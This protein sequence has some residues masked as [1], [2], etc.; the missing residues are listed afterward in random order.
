MRGCSRSS[1]RGCSRSGV[2]GRGPLRP[3]PLPPPR[4][5]LPLPRRAGGPAA[6]CGS[7]RSRPA[8]CCGRGRSPCCACCGRACGRC[9]AAGRGRH[10]GGAAG[11]AAPRHLAAGAPLAAPCLR[12][13]PALAPRPLRPVLAALAAAAPPPS[14][15]RGAAAAASPCGPWPS[16]AAPASGGGPLRPPPPAP[17]PPARA[18]WRCAAARRCPTSA[19]Y[20]WA[21][22]LS[23]LA[24]AAPPA[25]ARALTAHRPSDGG[26]LRGTPRCAARPPIIVQGV[27]ADTPTP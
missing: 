17:V 8:P 16:R 20:H 27:G 14:L 19:R 24:R 5:S 4:P 9:V 1:L 13:P 6:R 10:V 23:R 7:L 3:P 15:R 18:V 26:Q 2:G 11:Y 22:D 25:S 21:D 12:R